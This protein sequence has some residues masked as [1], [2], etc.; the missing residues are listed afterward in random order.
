M[1]PTAQK[2]IKNYKNGITS[3]IIFAALSVVNV[4]SYAI[5]GSYFL[6][7]SYI[8]L[9]VTSVLVE[10]SGTYVAIIASLVLV[11][12]YVVFAILSRKRPWAMIAALALAVIDTL[13][14]VL[15]AFLTMDPAV[16]LS[17]IID[18]VCHAIIIVELA[19]AVANREAVKL[20]EEEKLKGE[21]FPDQVKTEVLPNGQVVTVLDDTDVFSDA[22]NDSALANVK[23]KITITRKKAYVNAMLKFGVVMDGVEVVQLKNGETADIMVSGSAHAFC[24][25]LQDYNSNYLQIPAGT[26]DRSYVVTHIAKWFAPCEIRIDEAD[27]D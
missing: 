5:S 21:E 18:I 22:Q 24:I 26:E 23:R 11:A 16:I 10:L 27:N 9:I 15:D 4:F 25:Q 19:I 12:P 2:K 8:S 14:L 20:I 17:S 3:I 6:F 1:D 13:F 7:S